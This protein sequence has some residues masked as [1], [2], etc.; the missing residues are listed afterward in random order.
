[1]KPVQAP[2]GLQTAVL[3]LRSTVPS[4]L[5]RPMRKAERQKHM[6]TEENPFNNLKNHAVGDNTVR[7]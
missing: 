2:G 4:L 3:F 6:P 5:P 7:V 1:M